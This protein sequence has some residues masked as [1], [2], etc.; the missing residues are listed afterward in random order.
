MKLDFSVLSQPTT[1]AR[2]QVGT[3]GT[4]ALT[5][6]PTPPVAGVDTGTL[7]D[8]RAD[9]VALVPDPVLSVPKACPRASPAC[10]QVPDARKLNTGAVSPVS[11]FVPVATGQ[12]VVSVP[13]QAESLEMAAF[14]ARTERFQMLGRTDAQEL[15]QRLALRD[16]EEDDRRLCLECTWLGEAGR[17]IA[18]ANGRIPGSTRRLEPV[19]VIL[20]RCEAFGL[21]QGLL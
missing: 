10:P 4:Q 21:R 15:A 9:V 7:G 1:K 16:R 3:R 12:E 2:G 5:R 14:K 20:Q 6:V 18:A 19:Q 17:C 11:P 8:K 13:L